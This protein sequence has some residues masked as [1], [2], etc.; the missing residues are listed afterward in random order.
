MP[1]DNRTAPQQLPA[2]GDSRPAAPPI[3]P[4]VAPSLV[5]SH[6]GGT[7][8]PRMFTIDTTLARDAQALGVSGS[9]IW[10]MRTTNATDELKIQYDGDGDLIPFRAGN[11]IAGVAFYRLALT[12]AAGGGVVTMLIF[13]QLPGLSLDVR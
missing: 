13:N 12:N 5:A 2:D 7:K 9:A 11:F 6:G 4:I 10:I 3:S 1:L 8:A